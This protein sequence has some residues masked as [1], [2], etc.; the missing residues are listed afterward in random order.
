MP[1]LPSIVP[2]RLWNALAARY[3]YQLP[4]YPVTE[5]YIHHS[6]TWDG[7]GDP[8]NELEIIRSIQD[9]HMINRGW[10][11]IAYNFL[12]GRSGSVYTGR[13]W[14]NQGGA[15]GNGQDRHSLSIC[16]IGNYDTQNPSDAMMD[17]IVGWILTGIELGHIVPDVVIKGHRDEYQ[18][19]CPGRNI[20]KHLSRV[21]S[22]VAD[23]RVR[24][25][26]TVDTPIS[27]WY[28]HIGQAPDGTKDEAM[29]VWQVGLFQHGYLDVT[30][31]D[32]IKG[33]RTRE[34]NEAFEADNWGT[35]NGRPGPRSWPLLLSGPEPTP[36]PVPVK[37][38]PE[39][40]VTAVDAAHVEISKAKFVIRT[41]QGE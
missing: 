28:E 16:A 21:R 31:I 37:E 11:D 29:R 19:A 8:A 36:V 22:E 9:Y 34:A 12:V 23:G 25:E 13:G 3:A 39:E 15:T 27:T 10:S 30:E 32:G 38:I 4:V 1:L 5:V 17:A 18:T 40:V 2:R 41:Q 24:Q 35:S 6:V 14:R 20:Y 7:S 26:E 33:P